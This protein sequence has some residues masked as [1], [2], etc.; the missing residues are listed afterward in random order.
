MSLKH[1]M[2][3]QDSITKRLPFDDDN[4][5]YECFMHNNTNDRPEPSIG[6]SA[7]PLLGIHSSLQLPT[8]DDD[9][10]LDPTVPSLQLPPLTA[11]GL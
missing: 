8:L 6:A 7:T 5:Q 1:L 4:I 3:Q 2:H 10:L 9:L 11:R